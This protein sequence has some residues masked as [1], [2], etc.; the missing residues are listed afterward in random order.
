MIAAIVSNDAQAR[1]KAKKLKADNLIVQKNSKLSFPST[2][3]LKMAV[4]IAEH[5]NCAKNPT[6]RSEKARLKNNV[7]KFVGI[8][9]TLNR[10]WIMRI[11]PRT[12]TREKTKSKAQSA[13]ENSL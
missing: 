10:A 4:I 1:K 5:Q 11:F 8:D 9:D 3:L 2:F 13:I 12:D 7:F 6:A